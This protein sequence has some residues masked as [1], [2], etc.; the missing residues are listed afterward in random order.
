MSIIE[1]SH[2]D[3][4]FQRDMLCKKFP[5]TF[6]NFLKENDSRKVNLK[7]MEIFCDH[8]ILTYG[9]RHRGSTRK[10][11]HKDVLGTLWILKRI[12]MND[13]KFT[14]IQ[15]TLLGQFGI[16]LFESSELA[17]VEAID[18]LY[19]HLSQ[20]LGQFVTDLNGQQY[21]PYLK[22]RTLIVNIFK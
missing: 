16:K 18:S 11:L 9:F 22:Y 21:H 2:F 1:S 6:N 4:D 13:P 5:Y 14:S 8:Q 3:S 17:T 12:L 10:S 19:V 7:L 20:I 15:F